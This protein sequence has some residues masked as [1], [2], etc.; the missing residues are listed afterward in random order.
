MPISIYVQAGCLVVQLR[1]NYGTTN[2]LSGAKPECCQGLQLVLITDDITPVRLEIEGRG[3]RSRGS[4][5]RWEIS[6]SICCRLEPP[7][8]SFN[9]QPCD[10][11]PAKVA[12]IASMKTP[13]T[14]NDIVCFRLVTKLSFIPVTGY[15]PGK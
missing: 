9:Y 5:T 3:Y 1:H 6:P 15:P 14:L 11:R 2:I 13:A 12:K 7:A 4:F 8:A 10:S